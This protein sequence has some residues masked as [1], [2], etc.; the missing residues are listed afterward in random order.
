MMLLR[1]YLDNK[2]PLPQFL[3]NISVRTA[4]LFA[5]R[6][7]VPQGLYQGEVVL[8]RATSGEGDD[9]PYV[10]VYSDP[11]LGWDKRVTE[12]VKVY[13][14]PGGHS[15][16]LQEPNVEVMAEKMQAYINAVANESV[17]DRVHTVVGG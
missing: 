4:Y 12:G 2:L 17:P 16:M 3:Q 5:E 13:D 9:E 14:I 6:E 8:F 15:S 10:N 11:L 1:H 7:Y